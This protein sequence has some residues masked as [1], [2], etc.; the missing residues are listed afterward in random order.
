M[1]DLFSDPSAGRHGGNAESDAAH[2]RIARTG[3]AAADR[4]QVYRIIKSSGYAGMTLDE[5]CA[6]LDRPAN[7]LSGRVTELLAAGR[8]M[9]SGR[10]RATRSG[11]MAG[12]LV[13]TE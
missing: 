13:A 4:E 1:A 8:L 3:S 6:E 2:D 7:A 11:C 9:R 12:V 5:V 10:K